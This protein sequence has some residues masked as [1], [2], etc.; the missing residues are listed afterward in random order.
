LSVGGLVIAV[1]GVPGRVGLVIGYGFGL[2]YLLTLT[3]W[4][5][6]VGVDAWL[7]VAAA[8]ATFYALLGLGA[9][10]LTSSRG[11]PVWTASV[12]VGV[13][14][15]QSRWP[16]GG[17]PWGRLVWAT[18]DTPYARWLPWLGAEGV[19]FVV[20]LSGTTLAWACLRVVGSPV[21]VSLVMTGTAGL[22]LATSVI[23]PRSFSTSWLEDRE[24]LTVAA[25]QGNV[26][27]NGDELVANF[28]EVTDDH[29]RIT[30]NLA[31]KARQGLQPQPDLVI[32]PE[33]STA[34]DPFKNRDQNTGIEQAVKAIGVPVLVGAI[35]DGARPDQV[36]NQGVVWQPNG[37]TSERYT[38]RHPV[39]FG[40]YIPYRQ[41]LSGY[42]IGRLALI[43]RDMVRGDRT[44]PL[45]VGSA[46]LA[47]V[48]CFDVAFDDAIAD[49]VRAGGELVAVQTSNATFIE[50][51]QIEQQFAISRIRAMET[52]RVV[53]VASVNGLSGVIA[54]DGAV[55][56]AAE[57]R[58]QAVLVSEVPLIDELTPAV[59]LGVWPA[60]IMGALGFAASAFARCRRDP[61]QRRRAKTRSQPRVP[62]ESPLSPDEFS[63]RPG[64]SV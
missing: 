18:V 33:N 7:M 21:R 29:V 26:P 3:S 63:H 53:V 45:T 39:P 50:T 30:K 54:P 25:V 52:G 62:G 19:S 51:P 32:W 23:A 31:R 24:T 34:V 48:I 22:L 55:I 14:A 56:Q 61:R 17:F 28:S 16:F 35:V 38:K 15:L 12:W 1:R 5:R 36:L 49:Q 11:W 64:A 10:W 13:E 43:P 46:L 44:Q 20:A 57:P 47:D 4:L 8:A 37:D 27:G 58:T 9:A 41:V 42:S 40:E 59:R 6:V 2:A 60:I